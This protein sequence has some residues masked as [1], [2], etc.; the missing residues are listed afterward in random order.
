MNPIFEVERLH[1]KHEISQR[2]VFELQARFLALQQGSTANVT[3]EFT[4]AM[5]A[6]CTSTPGQPPTLDAFISVYKMFE[7]KDKTKEKLEFV[8]QWLVAL[9]H[10]SSS[11]LSIEDV[12]SLLRRHQVDETKLQA[13][14]KDVL[15]DEGHAL[16]ASAFVDYMLTKRPLEN[17]DTRLCIST[18]SIS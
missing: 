15:G 1:D 17:L 4:Q 12:Q 14:L 16:T 9:S 13:Q 7:Q 18:P 2:K 8:F 3:S 6:C 11:T 10:K 5:M